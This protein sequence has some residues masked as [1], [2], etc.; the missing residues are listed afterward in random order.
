[1]TKRRRK[2]GTT[3]EQKGLPNNSPPPPLPVDDFRYTDDYR[4]YLA[5]FIDPV[6]MWSLRVVNKAWQNV[7]D[8]RIGDLMGGG[9]LMVHGGNNI[10][11]KTNNSYM[12]NKVV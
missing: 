7:V 1:M 4:R 5:K 12:H 8:Q 3:L 2:K 10:S 11:N 6:S 9:S